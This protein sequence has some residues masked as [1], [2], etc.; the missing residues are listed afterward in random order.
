LVDKTKYIQRVRK[1]YEL[2]NKT[3]L[4]DEL[5]LEYFEKLVCL[6]S[7]I[8]SHLNPKEVIIPKNYG[9]K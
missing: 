5:A 9:G 1:L 6:V 4:S 8:T 3:T 7:T 2:K